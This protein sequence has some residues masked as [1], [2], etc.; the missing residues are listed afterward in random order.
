[1]GL[2]DFDASLAYKASSRTAKTTQRN[3]GKTQKQQQCG[4]RELTP[5]SYPLT[6]HT[7]WGVAE[8]IYTHTHSWGRD[9]YLKISLLVSF[10]NVC[11]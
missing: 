11:L 1:M 2:C 3:P 10:M 5:Q 6:S 8:Y 7:D 9:N 4:K